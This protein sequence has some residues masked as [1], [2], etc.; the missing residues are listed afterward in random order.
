CWTGHVLLVVPEPLSRPAGTSGAVMA[1]WRRF[2]GLLLCHRPVLIEAFFCALLMTVLGV[3]TS[4][5][6]QHLVDSVLVRGEVRL[7]NA[8]GGGMVLLVL[9]R[10]LFGPPGQFLLAHSGRRVDLPLMAGYARH[11]LSLPLSFFEMRRVGEILSR[12]NDAVKVRE[13]ISGATLTA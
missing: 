9:S 4:Y 6:V 5:Y 10:A 11:I 2:F 12:V 8:L 7:L 1:P 13:A 3:A